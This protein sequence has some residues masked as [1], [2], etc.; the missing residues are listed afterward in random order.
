MKKIN[1]KNKIKVRA[2]EV[3]SFFFILFFGFFCGFFAFLIGLCFDF[4]FGSSP[5]KL[6]S[7]LITVES[8]VTSYWIWNINLL[9]VAKV[10]DVKNSG[11]FLIL[12]FRYQP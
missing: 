3:E 6:H 8:E 11:W 4:S 2:R 10:K 12:V 5:L 1:V 9:G 7:S